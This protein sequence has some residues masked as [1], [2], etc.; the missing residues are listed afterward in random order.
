MNSV[1][2]VDLTI[3]V[4]QAAKTFGDALLVLLT[5]IAAK[6][7]WSVIVGDSLPKFLAALP[8]YAQLPIEAKTPEFD[9]YIG[10]LLGQITAAFLQPQP[11]VAAPAA[12]A[13]PAAA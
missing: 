1:I 12:P 4:P 3:K 6:K 8:Q 13:T 5:D 9:Q 2:M 11:V 10:L 7:D